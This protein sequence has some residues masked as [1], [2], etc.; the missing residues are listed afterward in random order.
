MII[1][2]FCFFE[3][4]REKARRNKNIREKKQLYIIN[5]SSISY[6]IL[7]RERQR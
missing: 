2:D 5:Y 4:I 3:I 6:Y 1:V 7:D